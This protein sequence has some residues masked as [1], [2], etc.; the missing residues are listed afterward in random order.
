M[1]LKLI[2]P[3]KII[4]QDEADY[5]AIPGVIGDFG[6][7]PGHENFVSAVRGGIVSISLANGET[8]NINISGGIC[9]VTNEKCLLLADG[10]R[11]EDVA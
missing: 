11:E 5:V 6:V 4:F 7:F 9:E 10:V 3:E 2:T 1:Q 8:R